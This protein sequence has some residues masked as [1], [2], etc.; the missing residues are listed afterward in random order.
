MVSTSRLSFLKFPM[1]KHGETSGVAAKY[2]TGG[3]RQAW[4]SV[5]LVLQD[6]GYCKNLNHVK[7][8]ICMQMY[9]IHLISK[10][11]PNLQNSLITSY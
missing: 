10:A 1:F 7:K 8:T 5:A 6:N 9:T 3:C 11:H 4:Q 2:V